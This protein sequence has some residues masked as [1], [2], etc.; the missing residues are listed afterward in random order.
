VNEEKEQYED[1]DFREAI[2]RCG[3]NATLGEIMEKLKQVKKEREN[4]EKT[5]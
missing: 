5:K 3:P 2:G 1:D 4:K